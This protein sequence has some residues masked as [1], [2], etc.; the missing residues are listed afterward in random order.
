MRTSLR[1]RF[2]CT[3]VKNQKMIPVIFFAFFLTTAVAE[4]KRQ[5]NSQ[6]AQSLF[7]SNASYLAL[8]S[9][10]N[11]DAKM[12]IEC[13]GDSYGYNL[14]FSDCKNAK[15]YIVYDSRQ[16]VFGQRDS[17]TFNKGTMFPLP[18][19]ILGGKSCGHDRTYASNSLASVLS[20]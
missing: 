18:Y 19:R 2:D 10:P 8:P 11:L 20:L 5:S 6:Q 4:F 1:G 3:Q 17:P 14:D 12:Y 13:D 15:N 9:V 16:F 7:L